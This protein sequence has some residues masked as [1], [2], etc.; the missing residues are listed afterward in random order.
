MYST[1]SYHDY[2]GMSD[3]A[4]LFTALAGLMVV[5]L[6]I[7]LAI[8]IIQIIAMWKLFSKAGQAGWKSLIPIYNFVI[9]FKISGLSPWLLL[10]FLL[11]F[12]PVV[13]SI[14]VIALMAVQSYKLAKSFGKD[15]GWAVG[16]YFLPSI[17][18]MI[19]AFGSSEYVGPG[20]EQQVFD[21]TVS[22]EKT[23]N[24]ENNE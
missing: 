14:I 3:V 16:L 13:G 12:I 4:T 20:G 23:E 8:Y 11:S 15:G 24:Q 22:T 7:A 5:V 19:L 21:A 1:Y 17:F 10:L 2:S 9:L 6:L 18:Y